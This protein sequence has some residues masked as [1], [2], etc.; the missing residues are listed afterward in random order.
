MGPCAQL[1]I[2]E[3]V[4]L[5][6]IKEIV[7]LLFDHT[8]GKLAHT[9]CRDFFQYALML[10]VISMKCLLLPELQKWLATHNPQVTEDPTDV[11]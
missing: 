3:L 9:L 1:L 10:I 5:Q 4:S 6:S 8:E 11:E 2:T 7:Y